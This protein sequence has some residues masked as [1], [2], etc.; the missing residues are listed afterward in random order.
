MQ[1]KLMDSRGCKTLEE[2]NSSTEEESEENVDVIFG[3][4]D[5]DS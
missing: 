3:E 5:D 1:C 2:F 4:E